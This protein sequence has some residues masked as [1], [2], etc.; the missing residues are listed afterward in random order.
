MST[1]GGD[2]CGSRD[3]SLGIAGMAAWMGADEV[4]TYRCAGCESAGAG[5]TEYG[6]PT[7]TVRPCP[8]CI[9]ASHLYMYLATCC[10]LQK[11]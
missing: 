6:G 10:K 7:E 5:G 2:V 1:T 3:R 8:G 9:F 11:G 4:S